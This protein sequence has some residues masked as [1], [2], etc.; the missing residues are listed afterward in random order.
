METPYTSLTHRYLA[1]VVL[2]AVSPLA[3]GTGER[4]IITDALVA[5]DTNGL[6]YLPGSSIAGVLRHL[7]EENMEGERVKH[8][9]GYQEGKKG[10]GSRLILTEGKLLDEQSKVCDGLCEVSSD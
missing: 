10:E 6:P 4:D 2:E 8:L 7:A 9:F 5:T 1:R 3:L